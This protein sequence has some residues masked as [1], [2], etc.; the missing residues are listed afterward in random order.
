MLKTIF[1]VAALGTHLPCLWLEDVIRLT[2]DSIP[3][4]IH[5]AMHE[6]SRMRQVHLSESIVEKIEKTND[7]D[8]REAL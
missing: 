1:N 5:L 6:Q 8:V 3:L 7:G 2:I 4:C